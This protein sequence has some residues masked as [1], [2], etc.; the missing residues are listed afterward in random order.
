MTNALSKTDADTELIDWHRVQELQD[1]VG[2]DGFEDVIALFFEEVEEVMA[3]LAGASASPRL[4]ADLHFLK[5][6]ALNLGFAVFARLCARGEAL[7]AAGDA[8]AVDL[9][10]LQAAYARSRAGFDAGLPELRAS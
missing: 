4:E 8:G 9:A 7:A 6:C 2:T 10:A 5:G 1:E 3:R